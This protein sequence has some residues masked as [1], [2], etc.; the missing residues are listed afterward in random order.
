MDYLQDPQDCL[1]DGKERARQRHRY[2]YERTVLPGHGKDPE[3]TR[4]KPPADV[5]R[6][7]LEWH[8]AIPRYRPPV[9]QQG[10]RVSKRRPGLRCADREPPPAGAQKT[11][12]PARRRALFW[13]ICFH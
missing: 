2:D 7:V 1:I 3:G 10:L 13:F 5:V 4:E 8:A 9:A 6:R 11:R 12:H